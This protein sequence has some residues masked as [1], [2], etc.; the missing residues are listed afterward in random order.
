[1]LVLLLVVVLVG[2][3]FMLWMK[4]LVWVFWIILGEVLLVRYS[5]ISGLNCVFVGNVV[6]MCL[7]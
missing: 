2:Y 5:V 6:R 4:L 7:W 1:M 3:S